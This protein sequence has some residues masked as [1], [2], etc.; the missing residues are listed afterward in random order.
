MEEYKRVS[1]WLFWI[2]V[3]ILIT[4]SV[5]E[6]LPGFISTSIWLTAIIGAPVSGLYVAEY[7]HK[8]R[9][10]GWIV[11]I[12]SFAMFGIVLFS[13]FEAGKTIKAMDFAAKQIHA[14]ENINELE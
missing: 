5:R 4:A 2:V 3:F 11:G 10:D 12:C 8:R 6:G 9:H 7:L 13:V 1:V 14:T